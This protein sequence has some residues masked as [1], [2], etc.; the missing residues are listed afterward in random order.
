MEAGKSESLNKILQNKYI[1]ARSH[2][3]F[4]RSKPLK[5]S[6]DQ[7]EICWSQWIESICKDVEC[8]FGILKG[9]WRILKTGI[10]LFGVESAYKIWMTCCALQNWFL[11]VNGLD[12]K[13]ESGVLSEWKGE[14][15]DLDDEDVEHY[16]QP[17][18][19][20]R[21][22]PP[23]ARWQYDTS[24]MGVGKDGNMSDAEEC[25]QRIPIIFFYFDSFV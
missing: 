22:H 7:R 8:T 21:L 12:K 14:L 11:E 23:A 13:W 18:A 20:Q 1:Y 5:V 10:R 19:L 4:R 15:G 25:N 16:G 9:R 2:S 6:S 17:F 3:P 24:S